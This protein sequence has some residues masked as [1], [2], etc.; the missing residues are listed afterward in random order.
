[1]T[2][3]ARSWLALIVACSLLISCGGREVEG[4]GGTQATLTPRDVIELAISVPGAAPARIT[5]ELAATDEART[6]G[7]MFRDALPE[8]A[9]MLF[10]FANDQRGGFWMKNTRIPLTIAYLDSSG[11]VLELHDGRPLDEAAL[12]PSQPYR[13]AL[14]VNQGWF[15]RHGLGV[16]AKVELPGDLPAAE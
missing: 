1:M 15:G 6:R 2:S 12:L 7:L 9:G 5:V 3:D 16:G 10:L 8:E 13:F 4:P 11:R 14:E